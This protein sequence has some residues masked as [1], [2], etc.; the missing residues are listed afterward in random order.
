MKSG[1]GFVA[2]MLWFSNTLELWAVLETILLPVV[3]CYDY[4]KIKSSC[5]NDKMRPHNGYWGGLI[6]SSGSYMCNHW[7]STIVAHYNCDCGKGRYDPMVRFCPQVNL[8]QAFIHLCKSI[9]THHRWFNST[10]ITQWLSIA[11]LLYHVVL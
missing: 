2:L 7:L 5:T 1:R 9:Q 8:F 10:L 6:L 11:N 3:S 4:E